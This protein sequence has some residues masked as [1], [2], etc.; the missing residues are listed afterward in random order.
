M[1]VVASD[2]DLLPYNIPNLEGDKMGNTFA[3]YVEEQEEEILKSLLGVTLYESFIE[4][5]EEDYPEDWWIALRDGAD[6]LYKGKTYEWVGMK[7]MLIP[8]IY[9]MWLRD[10][11]DAHTGIGVVQG[12]AEN[13]KVINPGKRI[14]RAYNKFSHIVG[15]TC[16]KK[17]TLFGYLQITG[18]SGTFDG[19]FDDSFDTFQMYFDYVFHDPGLMN[20]HNL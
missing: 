19:T 13:S 2:F 14:A 15:N 1:F 12:K 9:S 10:T 20:T 17:N 11:Y 6:Y 18:S 5:L 3:D 7:K 16:D 8:Y 4:G